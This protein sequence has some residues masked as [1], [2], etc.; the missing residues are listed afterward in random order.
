MDIQIIKNDGTKEQ[1]NIDKIYSHLQYACEGLNV[2]QV[3]I[4]KN[5]KLKFFNNMKSSS[6]QDSLIQSA[7]EMISEETP[8]YELCAGRLL[9]QKIRKE[10]YNQYE[11]LDFKTQVKKRIREGH[12]S[13]DLEVYSDEDLDFLESKIDYELDNQLSYSALKQFYDKYLIK[14]KNKTI[15]LPQEVLMLIPMSMFY[16]TKDLKLITL[17]YKLLS[18]RKISLPTPIMNGAR[19][20]YK[21]FISCN[22][23]NAGDS[24]DSLAKAAEMV[25]KCTSNKSGI[26]LNISFIRGLGARIGNPE[27]VKHTGILPLIKTYESATASLTQLARGG[28]SNLTAPFYHYEIELFSQLSDNKGT[29]ETRARHTDQTI[30]LNRWFMKKALAKEDIYLFHMNEVPGLYNLLGEEEKFNEQYERYA[31]SVPNRHKKKVNAWDLLGLFI[32]ERSITGRL[33]FTFADNFIKNSFKENLYQTN[34]CCE[35]SVPSHSLDGF[36]H[37]TQK[38]NDTVPEIGVCILGNINLGYIKNEEIPEAANFLVRFLDTM[39]EENDYNSEY[40]E[41]AA[42]N[43]RTL[44]IGIS[45]L[46]GYLAKNKL[47]YNTQEAREKIHEIMELFSYHL[48]KVSIQIAKENTAFGHDGEVVVSGRCKLFGDTVYSEALFPFERFVNTKYTNFKLKQ[49]WESLRRELQRYGIRNSSLMAVPPAGT[50]AEI[51]NST[52]GVEPPR[53]LV[54]IKT[55]KNSSFKKLVPFFKTSKHYY[56]TS[57]G[58]EFNNL[59]YFK[60]ISVIQKFVD[61][62]ISLNQYTDTTKTRKVKIQEIIEE[63]IECFNLGIK[64]LYYQNFRTT[65]DIDGL[66]EQV[67]CES[68]GC[69]V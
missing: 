18:Q 13:K 10:L 35:I 62:S 31:K 33:Y 19:T 14:N 17:G 36:N 51:S 66:S 67:G 68:G 49:D 48:H 11:P 69:S 3:D 2:S 52:N 50:S 22:L 5:A 41:Y 59:D 7:Q 29:V 27:R 1:L 47:F 9:N 38:H 15:E 12:Y 32:Y 54:T 40:I 20:V 26:G 28:S 4:I 39:I 57:W 63:L 34:L 46:F 37:I 8:D 43:R 44:G 42:K 16:K 64:T 61:Q 23:I 25:M 21:Q 24:T 65:D 60:L 45:N 30:I 55:D 53:G 6:I 58:L 56:T